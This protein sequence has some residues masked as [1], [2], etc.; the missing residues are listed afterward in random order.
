MMDEGFNLKCGI[1]N[2]V[3]VE[4]GSDGDIWFHALDDTELLINGNALQYLNN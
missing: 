3:V 2:S 1:L 4:K